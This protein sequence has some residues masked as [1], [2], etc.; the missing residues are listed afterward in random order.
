MIL[1]RVCVEAAAAA[2]GTTTTCWFPGWVNG[3][4]NSHPHHHHQQPPPQ[5]GPSGERR[6]HHWR[7]YKLMID[8][9]L[10]KGHHKLYRYDGQ[11]F[12]LAVSSRPASPP[13]LPTPRWCPGSGV[14]AARGPPVPTTRPTVSPGPQPWSLTSAW[15]RGV[16]VGGLPP[17]PWGVGPTLA[18]SHPA[19]PFLLID[20]Q[21][22]PGG[23]CRRSPGGRDLDQ[24]QGAGAVG[25]QIQGRTPPPAPRSLL[26][27]PE[28][29]NNA[30]PA[31]AR[32]PSEFPPSRTGWFWRGGGGR[33]ERGVPAAPL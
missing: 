12:S 19:P 4:E 15:S 22:P 7:S 9:A 10:K 28:F 27:L 6:N 2:A 11:H 3:M 20:V 32:P 18:P 24:K 26:P 30:S 25:A 21:Q 23:N 8:P 17:W 33:C 16:G 5:P 13:P 31:G 29:E 14:R 1:G